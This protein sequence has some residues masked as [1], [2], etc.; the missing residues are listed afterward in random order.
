MIL[1]IDSYRCP[2]PVSPTGALA[3]SKRGVRTEALFPVVLPVVLPALLLPIILPPTTWSLNSAGSIELQI[4][5]C[6][7]SF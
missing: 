2:V 1:Y 6:T 7:I 3:A 4:E 5:D